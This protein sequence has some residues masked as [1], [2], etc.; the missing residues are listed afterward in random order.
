M[1][2]AANYNQ[3]GTNFTSTTRTNMHDNPNPCPHENSKQTHTIEILRIN[4]E[5]DKGRKY[6]LIKTVMGANSSHAQLELKSH[7]IKSR[8]QHIA[9]PIIR[10]NFCFC[11]EAITCAAK[12]LAAMAERA[13]LS[14][15]R[16]AQPQ[17]CFL[18]HSIKSKLPK[19]SK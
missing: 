4:P 9:C 6:R 11:N 12:N 14:P 19:V 10:N 18:S 8:F 2:E 17:A 16:I 1:V 13:A 7:I 3:V 5:T 15:A